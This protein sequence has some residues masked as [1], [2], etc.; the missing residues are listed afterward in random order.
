MTNFNTEIHDKVS[1]FSKAT[2]S[3]LTKNIVTLGDDKKFKRRNT[4]WKMMVSMLN[5]SNLLFK[6]VS[7]MVTTESKQSALVLDM[8]D[9]LEITYETCAS[10]GVIFEGTDALLSTWHAGH[11]WCLKQEGSNGDVSPKNMLNLFDNE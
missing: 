3:I 5:G 11:K 1:L 2:E 8:I 7:D 4:R 6:T 10:Y 9:S